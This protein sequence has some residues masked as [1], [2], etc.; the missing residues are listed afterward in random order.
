[1]AKAEL[2]IPFIKSWEGGFVCDPDDLGGATSQGITLATFREW[3][4]KTHDAPLKPGEDIKRLQH[5]TGEEWEAIFRSGFWDVWQADRIV[6]QPIANILVDW[7]WLSGRKT[8]KRV[9][10]L[11]GVK[12]DGMVGSQTLAAVNSASP[13]P[14]FQIIKD[15]RHR[16]I[17]EICRVR[18]KNL[19][20]RK[21]WL[22]RLDA[23]TYQK[24]GCNE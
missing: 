19:K 12:A 9:Q 23:I 1:M 13:L 15:E 3:W 11:L 18:K 16:Y 14:L 22:R 2:L 20:Y 21:G 5:I 7:L 6:S 4:G 10:R 24:L 8:I 17:D